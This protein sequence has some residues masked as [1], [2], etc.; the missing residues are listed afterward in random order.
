MKEGIY[1]SCFKEF[2]KQNK[3]KKNKQFILVAEYSD[4][5]IEYLNDYNA[6]IVG[7]IV[8]FIVYNTEFYNKGTIAFDLEDDSDYLFV[9]DMSE[10]NCSQI[11][12]LDISSLMVILDGLSP[13]ITDFLDNLFQ[14]VPENTQILGGGAGKMTFEDE[15]VIF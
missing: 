4:F 8:P 13:N 10:L 9:P 5:E 1:Y 12:Q 14:S 11:E 6:D 2:L 7:A 3:D 15:P